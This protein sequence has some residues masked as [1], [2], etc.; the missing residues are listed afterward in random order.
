M[1][2]SILRVDFFGLFVRFSSIHET[3]RYFK[4]VL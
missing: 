2:L 4:L 1:I 3:I